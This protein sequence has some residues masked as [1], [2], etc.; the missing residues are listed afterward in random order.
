VNERPQRGPGRI[1]S[2]EDL[3]EF[4]GRLRL[5]VVLFAIPLAGLLFRL[6][7]L[8]IVEGDDL[9]RLANENFVREVELAPEDRAARAL[10][11]RIQHETARQGEVPQQTTP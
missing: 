8:Q 7:H 4:D 9:Y 11:E 2:R 6:H 5:L 10:R 3:R 1:T